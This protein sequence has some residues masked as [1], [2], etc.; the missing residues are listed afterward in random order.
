MNELYL[1]F[2]IARRTVARARVPSRIFP[3]EFPTAA[4]RKKQKQ[5]IQR[6]KLCAIRFAQISKAS[7]KS[8]SIICRRRKYE[9]KKGYKTDNNRAK[10]NGLEQ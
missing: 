3:F 7:G 2:A 4:K 5:N 8:A 9:R 1:S 6:P 10:R